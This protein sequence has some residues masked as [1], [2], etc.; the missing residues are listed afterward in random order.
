MAYRKLHQNT[1]AFSD[2]LENVGARFPGGKEALAA[3]FAGRWRNGAPIASFP[4]EAQANSVAEQWAQAKWEVEKATTAEAKGA[5]YA[6]LA[7]L[8]LK[9][10]SFHYNDDI[11]GAQCPMGAHARRV[12]PR[13]ALE[14]GQT[15]AFETPSALADRRRIIRRGLPYGD[16]KRE[17]NDDG[18]HGIV[19]MAIGASLLRQFEFVQQQW[20]NYGNDF[21]LANEKDPLLG[22]HGHDENGQPDGRMI[23]PAGPERDTAPYF[24]SRMPR[25]VET[26]GGEYFFVPSLTA[27]RMIAQGIVDP[28]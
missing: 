1:R 17:P 21:R 18:N 19:F 13:G 14:F 24:C 9:M 12:N 5:A 23:V 8:N 26:R 2:Y 11:P 28:T 20:I 25:F 15:L 10:V 7:D 3:K 16:S 27:L 4:S 22:N 6:R